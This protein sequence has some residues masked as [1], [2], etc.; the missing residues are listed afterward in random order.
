MDCE[1]TYSFY[2]CCQ[3]VF[4]SP[5]ACGGGEEFIPKVCPADIIAVACHWETQSTQSREAFWHPS[6]GNKE[7]YVANVFV[8]VHLCAS[9]S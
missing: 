2:W 7:N 5:Y 9:P 4:N 6:L 1:C 8:V 3:T